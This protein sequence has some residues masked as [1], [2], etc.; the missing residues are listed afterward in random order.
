MS[1]RQK[2]KGDDADQYRVSLEAAEMMLGSMSPNPL[3][4]NYYREKAR[5]TLMAA[6]DMSDEARL[7]YEQRGPHC[8]EDD[9]KRAEQFVR[10]SQAAH[11]AAEASR[12]R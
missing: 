12:A 6:P 4:A 5:R 11:Q 10:E 9:Y 2:A 1:N 3:V 8:S 7:W